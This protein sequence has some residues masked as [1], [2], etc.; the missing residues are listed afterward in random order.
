MNLRAFGPKVAALLALIAGGALL[1]GTDMGRR[2]I[3]MVT[4]TDIDELTTLLRSYGWAAWIAGFLIMTL[5][6]LIGLIPAVFLLGALVIIFGWGPGL[7]IG[8]A[9]EIAGSAVA[10]VLFRYFG[11]GP[12]ARWLGK[13]KGFSKWDE[14]TAKHGF[15]SIFLIRLAP[16]VPSAAINLAAAVSSVGFVPFIL[17]TALGKI[18]T[19]FLESVVGH[20]MWNPAQNASRL[21]LAV[22]A[23]G[24]LAYALKR[25]R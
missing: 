7:F 19:I 8:W 12:V 16:F 14:W 25:Y 15:G 21:V 24:V 2:V 11:R 10:F 20:D 4:L 5:Q 1:F 6:T 3:N 23:L 22:A 18:P 9:G 13:K 17:G